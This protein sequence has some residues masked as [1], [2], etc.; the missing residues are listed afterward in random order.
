MKNTPENPI[1]DLV[2]GFVTEKQ[3]YFWLFLTFSAK[4]RLGIATGKQGYFCLF[5]WFSTLFSLI[6]GVFS[7]FRPPDHVFKYLY[8]DRGVG[9]RGVWVGGGP[10]QPPDITWGHL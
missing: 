4:T 10:P 5:R 3:G 2:P 6:F 8:T 9:G 1:F 7:G